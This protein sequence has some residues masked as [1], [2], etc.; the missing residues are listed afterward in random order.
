MQKVRVPPDDGTNHVWQ[1]V[2][3]PPFGIVGRADGLKGGRVEELHVGIIL[4]GVECILGV[5]EL[6]LEQ[7]AQGHHPCDKV[8]EEEPCHDESG[9]AFLAVLLEGGGRIHRRY[10]G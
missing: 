10:D 4:D 3:V 6:N 5:P 8:E 7:R 2:E 1:K 9:P